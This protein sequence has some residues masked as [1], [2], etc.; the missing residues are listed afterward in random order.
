MYTV[1]DLLK[2]A[3]DNNVVG[4]LP[5]KRK[6]QYDEAVKNGLISRNA[7]PRSITRE[8]ENPGIPTPDSES[9]PA[10]NR[11]PKTGQMTISH[12]DP[13]WVKSVSADRAHGY[14][15]Y[16]AAGEGKKGIYSF[17]PSSLREDYTRKSETGWIGSHKMTDGSG[18]VVTDLAAKG[19]L[20]HKGE[21]VSYPLLVPT[22]TQGEINEVLKGKGIPLSVG[23][24]ARAH[25]QKRLEQGLSPYYN[26]RLTQY[27]PLGITGAVLNSEDNDG[28]ISAFLYGAAEGL[29]V[30]LPALF[31]KAL[32]FVTPTALKKKGINPGKILADFVE[33]KKVE[34]FG[35]H[36][37]QGLANII[38]E[39]TKML[40]PSIVPGGIGF[41]GG[42]LLLK[43]AA[44]S[45]F[46]GAARG[47]TTTGK[48][49]RATKL[50]HSH[51]K[52]FRGE[53]A[54][55][56]LKNPSAIAEAE[57]AMHSVNKALLLYAQGATALT[58]GASQGQ[59][60]EDEIFK[61]IDEL[62]AQGEFAEAEK[63]RGTLWYAP[64]STA[65]IE[66]TGE[67]FATKYLAKLFGL[68]VNDIIKGGGSLKF[69]Q[70]W[71]KNLF[72]VM[73]VEVGTEIGQAGGQAAVEKY[74]DIRPAANILYEMISVVGPTIWMTLMTAGL[75][76]HGQMKD[77][78]DTTEARLRH[79]R[80]ILHEVTDPK[81]KIKA[82]ADVLQPNPEASTS[83]TSVYTNP[84]TNKTIEFS[85]K[86]EAA[87]LNTYKNQLNK[88]KK[89][90][91]GLVSAKARQ[92]KR[93]EISTL[94]ALIDG[95]ESHVN[96][97][98]GQ[99]D[100]GYKIEQKTLSNAQR[101]Y[102]KDVDSAIG[103]PTMDIETS[104]GIIAREEKRIKGLNKEIKKEKD[105]SKN[106]KRL[107]Y[108]ADSNKTI[109]ENREDIRKAQEKLETA[110][111]NVPAPMYEKRSWFDMMRGK[112]KKE[113][114]IVAK[115][116]KTKKD[117]IDYMNKTKAATKEYWVKRAPGF[118]TTLTDTDINNMFRSDSGRGE[119]NVK[120]L[121][122]A[123]VSI[124]EAK[125]ARSYIEGKISDWRKRKA[126]LTKRIENISKSSYIGIPSS[127]F[128]M[129][130]RLIKELDANIKLWNKW[131]KRLDNVIA[132]LEV[133]EAV[134]GS[135]PEEK[136]VVKKEE[137]KDKVGEKVEEKVDGEERADGE[138]GV[139]TS[140]KYV[141]AIPA[142]WDSAE[143][144]YE[145]NV[146]KIEVIPRH[147]IKQIIRSLNDNNVIKM[148]YKGE[149]LK[150][151]FRILGI[152]GKD[153]PMHPDNRYS[154]DYAKKFEMPD[155][156]EVLSIK[157]R[158][159]VMGI[160]ERTLPG[161]KKDDSNLVKVLWG[162]EGGT[163]W[164]YN[165]HDESGD[166]K[167][168]K[169]L[170]ND[171]NTEKEIE[172]IERAAVKQGFNIFSVLALLENLGKITDK[173]G[174]YKYIRYAHKK[175]YDKDKNSKGFSGEY[176]INKIYKSK[177]K[178]RF[179]SMRDHEHRNDANMVVNE[180]LSS[181]GL[182]TI[183]YIPLPNISSNDMGK[184]LV[185]SEKEEKII[186]KLTRFNQL[187]IGNWHK[188]V[189]K[190]RDPKNP[191]LNPKTQAK[192]LRTLAFF[193]DYLD[194]RIEALTEG[195]KPG[196]AK[197]ILF[198]EYGIVL[199]KNSKEVDW[200]KVDTLK[201]SSMMNEFTTG[202]SDGTIGL[203]PLKAVTVSGWLT[204]LRSFTEAKKYSYGDNTFTFKA[205]TTKAYPGEGSTTSHYSRAANNEW[206]G[207]ALERKKDAIA[208]AREFYED[209]KKDIN[210]SPK[211]IQLRR[212]KMVN[213]IVEYAYYQSLLDV[214]GR[215]TETALTEVKHW[216]FSK[217][218]ASVE[219]YFT[220]AS[221]PKNT[222]SRRVNVLNLAGENT[223]E[224]LQKMRREVKAYIKAYPSEKDEFVESQY[225]IHIDETTGNIRKVASNKKLE[226]KNNKDIPSNNQYES[227]NTDTARAKLKELYK[228][229]L[230]E[231]EEQYENFN[232]D[233]WH[234]ALHGI[235]HLSSHLRYIHY[236]KNGPMVANDLGHRTFVDNYP[237]SQTET[238]VDTTSPVTIAL[239]AEGIRDKEGTLAFS[240]TDIEK[241]MNYDYDHWSPDRSINTLRN[242]LL[243]QKA[244]V[245]GYAVNPDFMNTVNNDTAAKYNAVFVKTKDDIKVYY[246]GALY[247]IDDAIDNFGKETIGALGHT[248]KDRLRK[249]YDGLTAAIK[250]K[251]GGED[252]YVKPDE[253]ASIDDLIN[254]TYSYVF[255]D[256]IEWVKKYLT[257][258]NKRDE[259]AADPNLK[260]LIAAIDGKYLGKSAGKKMTEEDKKWQAVSEYAERIGQ[261]SGKV[262]KAKKKAKRKKTDKGKGK[263][264]SIG[265]EIKGK[266]VYT[267][268]ERADR[269]IKEVK[270][271]AAVL[272]AK[273]TN[274]INKVDEDGGRLD[275]L[276]NEAH[277]KIL[278]AQG[279]YRNEREVRRAI[280]SGKTFPILGLCSSKTVG[281]EGRLGED[282][283]GR[284]QRNTI[285]IF[286]GSNL[287]TLLEEMVHDVLLQGAKPVGMDVSI[288]NMFEEELAAKSVAKKILKIINA[289][290]EAGKRVSMNDV[291]GLFVTLATGRVLV[292]PGKDV[293][294]IRYAIGNDLENM[295]KTIEDINEQMVNFEVAYNKGL[296]T[297]GQEKWKK[298][299][300]EWQNRLKTARR[301]KDRKRVKELEREIFLFTGE[302]QTYAYKMLAGLGERY[303]KV[304]KFLEFWLPM[305]TIN[306]RN[307]VLGQRML[308]S[309]IVQQGERLGIDI[310]NILDKVD[311][312]QRPYIFD[313]MRGMGEYKNEIQG[314]L[315]ATYEK[316]ETVRK[317]IRKLKAE[318]EKLE[319]AL[320]TEHDSKFDAP[321]KRKIVKLTK[322]INEKEATEP[323]R[324]L[325]ERHKEIKKEFWDRDEALL[326]EGKIDPKYHN[327]ARNIK[328]L[329]IRL[330]DMLLDRGLI[331]H[332]TYWKW[333]GRYAHYMYLRNMMP[334]SDKFIRELDSH[335]MDTILDGGFLK[336]M[337]DIPDEERHAM[338]L[339]SDVHLV[340]PKGVA[341]S[342]GFMAKHD[343]LRTLTDPNTGVSLNLDNIKNVEWHKD[344]GY[345]I[346]EKFTP[347]Q[348]E[349]IVPRIKGQDYPEEFK[350]I[351]IIPK[352][353]TLL[354]P[355]EKVAW[356][357][358]KQTGAVDKIKS[359][360]KESKERAMF[361]LPLMEGRLERMKKLYK[362][363]DEFL[364][365]RGE[366]LNRDYVKM[367][368]AGSGTYGPLS[369]RLLAKPVANDIMPLMHLDHD[370]TSQLFSGLVRFNEQTTMAFKAGKVAINPPTMFRNVISNILQNNLR[371]RP[372]PLVLSDLV[373]AVIS[374]ATKD[375]Y[376]QEALK[377]GLYKGVMAEEELK[378]IAEKYESLGVGKKPYLNWYAFLSW[379]G[380]Q[381]KWYGGIDKLAK[382]SIYRQLRKE[383]DLTRLG[384]GNGKKVS[385]VEAGRIANKYGM[386]Y[387]LAN[388]GIKQ[389]RRQFMP[390]VTYQYKVLPL[391]LE[392]FFARPWVLGKWVAFLGVGS[393]SLA[394]MM[395]KSLM[396]IDDE[397]WERLL[398]QL[399]DFIKLNKTF[400]PVP[401]RSAEG[402]LM[403]FDGS[404][405]MP[406]GTWQAIIQDLSDKEI[407]MA[408]RQLGIS[409][410]LLTVLGTLGSAR[411][412]RPLVDQFTKQEIYN[413]LDTPTTKYLKMF[414]WMHNIITP[415]V[416][417]NIVFSL[418]GTA[419]YTERQGALG[420]LVTVSK[421]WITGERYKD[422]WQR[423]YGIEQLGRFIGVN[424][425]IIESAQTH[426]IIRAK[427]NA[428][429]QDFRRKMRSPAFYKDT[430]A[431]KKAVTML[432]EKIEKISSMKKD[433]G[434]F[435][436]ETR[437]R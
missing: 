258:I 270:R 396:G 323:D 317:E 17:K 210:A 363:V 138:A 416:I 24:K 93:K 398:K 6:K 146:K 385:M 54:F 239:L 196:E 209:T 303:W 155:A 382:L 183:P 150:I 158:N 218:S 126:S 299:I 106:K 86:K 15:T 157:D 393:Y 310:G 51:F 304:K 18:R 241:I 369:G 125:E 141:G 194:A 300:N 144:T 227:F 73:G 287:E 41:A 169:Y 199:K 247:T 233:Q 349:K 428:L 237:L 29:T 435:T 344:K 164:F 224:I 216:S 62:E 52:G 200:G 72:K 177:L 327:M 123:G 326:L 301:N 60:T 267:T 129:E 38:Y 392:S 217:D 229:T 192:Y 65:I 2:E 187:H 430:A 22:L 44:I 118:K 74:S 268:K 281:K 411:R 112:K 316:V 235:R 284:Q 251:V 63:V 99:D 283:G 311:A 376:H 181:L 97:K 193:D 437:H 405:F 250:G 348:W 278:L 255:K 395:A 346:R 110:K 179:W 188:H 364:K 113:G 101:E 290:K 70:N 46:V 47:A 151:A 234:T 92:N 171:E 365:S 107:E 28:V 331:T 419:D 40:A 273:G 424:A 163:R 55:K 292:K 184:G 384:F 417:E 103:D 137:G 423:G 170:M 324:V 336:E 260:A 383:G 53:K 286:H 87:A 30:E 436:R 80:K 58:F 243:N 356:E 404:Y 7:Q 191:N 202:L 8:A 415:G 211:Q 45:R 130:K 271:V 16:I 264:Y 353:Y 142:G 230:P 128:N 175:L 269:D 39:G 338:G 31:G 330:G 228:L 49:L 328:K 298:E 254:T 433:P 178:N 185:L 104:E 3:R 280:E 165:D 64:Y 245:Y 371:G 134:K 208:G 174:W 253:N 367:G 81:E 351:V 23:E 373:K 402:K 68:G 285:T 232:K 263:L 308:T 368:V 352:E 277:M 1:L 32:E 120:Q 148:D 186:N 322:E 434:I 381:T 203:N 105:K 215:A 262:P 108:I 190:G 305:S 374:M 111:E 96:L 309:G 360:D 90:L 147:V 261:K 207:K 293:S 306:N 265:T 43:L 313:Y 426:A 225:F 66:S 422:R 342:I 409:N 206:L 140:G 59:R 26:K 50:S 102:G 219:F 100:E 238:K 167:D 67:F 180:Y 135:P 375:Q 145:N 333:H 302:K 249:G 98:L 372:L 172:A 124:G 407:A 168:V 223:I 259:K 420:R 320:S 13:G 133:M 337:K 387:S 75:G 25:A 294:L 176:D 390:F 345:V 421:G 116:F 408:T 315:L 162:K 432:H 289:K 4:M 160:I 114:R 201:F 115:G 121:I 182:R 127:V 257:E 312:R 198:D 36:Q 37:Y 266:G 42:R 109:E 156:K 335:N 85:P 195:K 161:L 212:A 297:A 91:P 272:G 325:E 154:A 214:A 380:K 48:I 220:K 427:V 21:F 197:K 205:A 425:Q 332:E 77:F 279:G 139:S 213:H 132:T 389:L 252:G 288:G 386:D 276:N 166:A 379:I 149:R 33:D 340:V 78:R 76:V 357:I 274:Y 318:R 362:P 173:V 394:Q 35:E 14:G 361:K 159:M 221:E 189:N 377:I 82:L 246:G 414:S 319:L 222:R 11:D 231:M 240:S 296:G 391:L 122:G 61:R 400:I 295:N 244:E 256:E 71:A 314:E 370:R 321:S 431:V 347:D 131:S 403:W 282:R 399:P 248:N 397:E 9:N 19:I 355:V 117:A 291:K 329:Q 358:S 341:A 350:E 388:R 136:E 204:A 152:P 94:E 334:H 27:M 307:Y 10:L 401:W 359:Y 119:R 275:P 413:N 95:Y 343:Y 226:L 354:W 34:W 20:I 88:A 339:V 378:S 429:K 84:T 57:L 56:A 406:W 89:R 236:N 412:G 143:N 83:S 418:P 69:V 366:I 153:S 410:P 242:K 5:P 12:D 79:R